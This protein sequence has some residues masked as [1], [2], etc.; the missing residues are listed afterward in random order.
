[1]ADAAMSFAPLSA[2]TSSDFMRGVTIDAESYMSASQPCEAPTTKNPNA[3]SRR[4]RAAL[5]VV[6]PDL[7]S[8]S[9]ASIALTTSLDSFD[10]EE[11]SLRIDGAPITLLIGRRGMLTRVPRLKLLSDE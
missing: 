8:A 1:M 11:N 2:G 7:T 10:R 9:S 4:S 5:P 3:R 6:F